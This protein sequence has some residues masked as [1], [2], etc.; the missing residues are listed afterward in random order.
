MELVL[1]S[2]LIYSF[3]FKS[4]TSQITES[5]NSII[6]TVSDSII[7]EKTLKNKDSKIVLPEKL[8]DSVKNKFTVVKRIVETIEDKE[9]TKAYGGVKY[10][11]EVETLEDLG[12][13]TRQEFNESF[14]ELKHLKSKRD[15]VF[16]ESRINKA[17]YGSEEVVIKDNLNSKTEAKEFNLTDNELITFFKSVKKTPQIIEV[18]TEKDFSITC[19]EGT[20]SYLFQQNLL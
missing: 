13:F 5:T 10:M 9:L 20:K 19:K 12:R 2:A 1:V 3:I 11:R 17:K 4:E 15:T 14:P 8:V 6:K 16:I 7:V 18:N